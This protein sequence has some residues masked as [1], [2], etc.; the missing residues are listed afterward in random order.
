MTFIVTLVYTWS[1]IKPLTHSSIHSSIYL[2][3]HLF[4]HS[5]IYPPSIHPFNDPSIHISIHTFI[6]TSITPPT[7]FPTKKWLS[8]MSGGILKP[9]TNYSHLSRTVASIWVTVLVVFHVSQSGTHRTGAM[10]WPVPVRSRYSKSFK[11]QVVLLW[12]SLTFLTS[13]LHLSLI[14]REEHW[15]NENNNLEFVSTYL[16]FG[17]ATTQKK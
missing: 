1:T 11:T 14:R 7:S 13:A 9:A 5:F 10:F 17:K 12:T 15:I 16:Y 3:I 4:I 2:S 8:L 6:H